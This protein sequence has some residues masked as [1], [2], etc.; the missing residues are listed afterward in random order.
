MATK[1]NFSICAKNNCKEFEFAELTGLYNATTNTTGWGAPNATIGTTTSADLQVFLP[2]NTT[3]TPDF[4][5]DLFAE[6]PS[7]PTTDDTQIYTIYNTTLGYSGRVID[8]IW[9]FVYL[10]VADDVTYKQTKYIA[11][12][13]NLQCCVSGLFADID[14]FECD[15]MQGQIDRALTAMAIFEA[16]EAAAACGNI[17]KFD[18]L[19][20]ML[21]RMCTNT[22]CCG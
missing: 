18:K 9:K 6:T 12:T 13:C 17:T 1:L 3:V 20:S 21:Q 19:K 4:T 7:W 2:G 8:G 5:F 10:V 11:T 22:N 15:C 14:D 16:M